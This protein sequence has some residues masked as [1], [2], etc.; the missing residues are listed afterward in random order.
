MQRHW[1]GD[2]DAYVGE[3]ATAEHLEGRGIGR[4]LLARAEEWAR[5]RG[6]D[7]IT[8]D[9]GA[10]NTHARGFYTSLGSPAS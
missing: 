6:L 9:A 1:T 2:L 5:G 3:L 8:L 10:A 4:A 7:R